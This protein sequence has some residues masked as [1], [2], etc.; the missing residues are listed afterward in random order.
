MLQVIGWWNHWI[1]IKN[2]NCSST[3]SGQKVHNIRSQLVHPLKNNTFFETNRNHVTMWQLTHHNMIAT[4]LSLCCTNT[5]PVKREETQDI[6]T[7]TVRFTFRW[8]RIV[9]T[10]FRKRIVPKILGFSAKILKY[11]IYQTFAVLAFIICRWF[12]LYAKTYM[13]WF[14]TAAI[15]HPLMP[16]TIARSFVAEF[17]GKGNA[18]MQC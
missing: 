17:V 15:P 12:P 1:F 4:H 2:S 5:Y 16:P 13:Y 3:G 6:I 11:I 9:A 10:L 7:S 14:K 8:Y 18:Y